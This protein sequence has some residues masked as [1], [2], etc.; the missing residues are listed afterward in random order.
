MYDFGKPVRANGTQVYVRMFGGASW[1]RV[2][3]SN[4]GTAWTRVWGNTSRN[5]PNSSYDTYNDSFGE[6]SYRYWAFATCGSD[7][8]VGR[9]KLRYNNVSP[10]F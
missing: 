2:E 6:V 5:Y 10:N 7:G 8:T 3:G 4:D 9:F 1:H